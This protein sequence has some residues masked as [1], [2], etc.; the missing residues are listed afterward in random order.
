MEKQWNNAGIQFQDVIEHDIYLPVEYHYRRKRINRA[1]ISNGK[2][3][4][5]TESFV[6][7]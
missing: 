2:T 4:P 1:N 7:K 3:I 5:A 6:L